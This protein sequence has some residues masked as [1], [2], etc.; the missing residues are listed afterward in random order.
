M[1]PVPSRTGA[2]ALSQLVQW[3]VGGD[4]ATRRLEY[5]QD[6]YT[7]VEMMLQ[8]P[9]RALTPTVDGDVLGVLAGAQAAFTPPQV[10]QLLGGRSEAGVRKALQRLASHGVVDVDQV[11]RAYAYS[12]NRDHLLAD[13]VIAIAQTGVRFVAALQAAL[14]G[15][16][17]PCSY[18]AIFGSAARGRMSVDSD[19][20]LLIVRPDEVPQDGS[21]WQGQVMGLEDV[22]RRMT[23]NDAQVLELSVHEVD[24]GLD[25]PVMREIQRDA[26]TLAGDAGLLW[27]GPR[28]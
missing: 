8:V 10:H 15:W 19:I 2:S 7:I 18:A 17:V 27:R 16:E 21:P 6:I 24:H 22:V 4:R 9:F 3:G 13:Q 25:R 26:V 11:G 1:S 23:G 20:D 14:A 28:G 12:L 5:C